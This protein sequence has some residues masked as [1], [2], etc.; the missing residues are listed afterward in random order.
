[1]FSEL[2]LEWSKKK[3]EN[4]GYIHTVRTTM[5]NGTRW[6]VSALLKDEFVD[7]AAKK[8]MLHALKEKHEELK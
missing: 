7:K 5:P 1:M 3:Y 4:E 6:E 8:D 2:K